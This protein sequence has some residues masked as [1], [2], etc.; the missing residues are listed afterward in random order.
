MKWES[1][2]L[3]I[4]AEKWTNKQLLHLPCRNVF[5]LLFFF[6]FSLAKQASTIKLFWKN[7]LLSVPHSCSLKERKL[8]EAFKTGSA[9]IWWRNPSQK[10]HILVWIYPDLMKNPFIASDSMNWQRFHWAGLE[11]TVC[12]TIAAMQISYIDECQ[13]FG[14]ERIDCFFKRREQNSF[15]FSHF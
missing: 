1:E 14:M 5:L 8:P 3:I 10:V 12:V 15:T 11:R 7:M 6:F 13:V 4:F 2:T 9:M